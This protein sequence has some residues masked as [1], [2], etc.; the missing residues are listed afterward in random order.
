MRTNSQGGFPDGNPR[1]YANVDL[2]QPLEAGQHYCLRLW[3]NMVDSSCYRTDRFNAFIGYGIPTLCNDVD[4]TWHNFAQANF[5]IS[6]VDTAEWT[7]LETEFTANGGETNLTLG[8]FQFGDDIHSTFLAD[9]SHLLQSLLGLYFIDDVELWACQVG[10]G[11]TAAAEP[12]RIYPNPADTRLNVV[13]ANDPAR[14]T[15]L[16]ATGRSLQPT[17]WP[18]QLPQAGQH[19]LDV[20][21]LAPG[22]YLLHV[23]GSNGHTTNHRF[24]V[25]H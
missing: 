17:G 3:M 19:T 12:T 6:A 23:Q 1:D 7:M 24:V 5:D 10:V 15:L 25:E 2:S 8:A 14:I 21:G 20:S 16:D 13:L 9:H 11:E 18:L 22:Q 4:T